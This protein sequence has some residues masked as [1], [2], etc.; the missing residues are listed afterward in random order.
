MKRKC[1]QQPDGS[2]KLS[3]L[4]Y[5]IKCIRGSVNIIDPTFGTLKVSVNPIMNI[6]L[7]TNTS[8]SPIIYKLEIGPQKKFQEINSGL[9]VA[10]SPLEFFNNGTYEEIFINFDHSG[11]KPVANK[12]DIARFDILTNMTSG[13]IPIYKKDRSFVSISPTTIT[14]IG[15]HTKYHYYTNLMLFPGVTTPTLTG[16]RI[17]KPLFT[18]FDG[19][20]SISFTFSN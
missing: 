19:V 15:N 20:I 8:F 6:N 14:N 2:F 11:L 1:E 17:V 16:F 13:T 12:I 7:E 3:E 4:S 9:P 18:G 5:D 10:W